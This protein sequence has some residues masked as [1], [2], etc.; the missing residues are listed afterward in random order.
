MTVQALALAME[1]LLWLPQRLAQH[2]VAAGPAVAV[3]ALAMAGALS[4]PPAVQALVPA[5]DTASSETL[6]LEAVLSV[7]RHIL[8]LCYLPLA[9]KL[10]ETVPDEQGGPSSLAQLHL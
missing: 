6:V 1:A 5:E 10:N 4:W 2:L 3:Q 9:K 7:S 8:R